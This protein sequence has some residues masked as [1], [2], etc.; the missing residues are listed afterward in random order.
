MKSRKE[1]SE[2]DK[3]KCLLWSNRHCCLCG[4]AC[5]TDIEIAHIDAKAGNDIDNAIPLCY[6]CHAEIGRYNREHPRG[7]KYRPQELKT[8]REQIYEEYTRHLVPPILFDLHP[9]KGE[10]KVALP[11]VVFIISH[12]GDSLPVKAQIEARV[13]LGSKDLGVIPYAKGYYSGETVWTLNPRL[14]FR[15]NFGVPKECVDSDEKLW[16]ELKVRIIDMYE[17]V[18]ELLPT[19]H[20]YYRDEG[21][22]FT[23]PTSFSELRRSLYPS[24]KSAD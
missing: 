12:L 1:F 10:P 2:A 23:E 17:R 15:G 9:R 8:R 16:V 5:G 19:C 7:N 6:D 21:Y 18:H 20:H 13:F 11:T 3:V 22:W 24:G 4:K 14:T